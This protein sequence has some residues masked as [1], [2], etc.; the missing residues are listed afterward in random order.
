[1]QFVI[2]VQF[3]SQDIIFPKQLNEFT[4]SVIL[5]S[6][7]IVVLIGSRPL[8]AIDFVFVKQDSINKLYCQLKV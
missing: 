2:N 5:L 3:F 7:T 4:C 6:I 1:M 8:N